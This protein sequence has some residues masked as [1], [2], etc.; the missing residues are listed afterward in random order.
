VDPTR[1]STRFLQY[2]KLSHGKH[3]WG[4]LAK[5]EKSFI[6]DFYDL[7]AVVSFSVPENINDITCVTPWVCVGLLNLAEQSQLRG[8]REDVVSLDSIR[9]GAEEEVKVGNHPQTAFY[10]RWKEQMISIK[11]SSIG[12]SGDAST[13]GSKL[14]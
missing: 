1:D 8:E 9:E 4:R 7:Y 11:F 3:I 6:V 14:D 10:V 12:P 2:E 13:S 5:N